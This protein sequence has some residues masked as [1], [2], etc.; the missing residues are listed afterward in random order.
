MHEYTF[1]DLVVKS[2]ERGVKEPGRIGRVTFHGTRFMVMYA[3]A[4]RA[5]RVYLGVVGPF[6]KKYHVEIPSKRYTTV[7]NLKT[8]KPQKE[9]TDGS[10]TAHFDGH[11]VTL[12]FRR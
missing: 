12:T 5:W 3:K 1:D 8:G 7:I 4:K 10:V 9:E 11:E 6:K 2:N